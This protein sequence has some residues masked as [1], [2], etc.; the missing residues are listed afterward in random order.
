MRSRVPYDNIQEK[1]NSY[2]SNNGTTQITMADSIDYSG[3]SLEEMVID[4]N[5]RAMEK[6]KIGLTRECYKLLKYSE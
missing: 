1:Q 5:K 2:I 4:L 6:L 3:Q